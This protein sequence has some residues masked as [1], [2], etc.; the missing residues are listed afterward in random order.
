MFLFFL[1]IRRPPRSTRTDTL[2]PDTTLFRSFRLAVGGRNEIRRALLGNLE[3]FDLVEVADQAAL[4]F[5]RRVRHRIDQG[6]SQGHG[7]M[8]ASVGKGGGP[9][10]PRAWLAIA[11]QKAETAAAGPSGCRS[12]EH[13]SE[14]QSLM[15]ISY[16][17]FCLKNKKEHN[18]KNSK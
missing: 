2:F 16:A 9:Y 7:D 12:E 18:C 11:R 8:I 4:R 13:T 5:T 6:G 1:M 15:R 10:Q 14:L 3:V 17:V